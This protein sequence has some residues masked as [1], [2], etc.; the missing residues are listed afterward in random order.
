MAMTKVAEV[1]VGSSGSASIEFTGIAGTGKD[2]LVLGSFRTTTSSG[3]N[4]RGAYIRFN[5]DTGSNYTVRRLNGI[6]STAQSDVFASQTSLFIWDANDSGSTSN[7]FSNCLAYVPNYTSSV[8][9]SVSG[10]DV[11][12]ANATFSIQQIVAG[13]WTGTSAITSL[14]VFPSSGNFAEFST[15]SLYI[16]S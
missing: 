14:T 15:A 13:T 9:K 16:I 6:G 7:T 8:A 3:A 11:T 2:L 1:V 12:E 4:M 5:G 10:D